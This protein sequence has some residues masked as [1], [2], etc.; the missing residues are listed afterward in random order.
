[1]IDRDKGNNREN[2]NNLLI[3]DKNFR[4]FTFSGMN[5]VEKMYQYV[6]ANSASTS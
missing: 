2:D 1:M 4:N 5:S 3:T 6:L